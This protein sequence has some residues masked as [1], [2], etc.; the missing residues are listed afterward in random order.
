MYP[1]VDISPL[2]SEQNSLIKE[3]SIVYDLIYTPR[4]T[5]FLQE[6]QKQG[7][8][9]FDGS[10]MLVQQGAIAFEIWT[11]KKP[12]VEVMRQALWNQ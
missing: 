3:G 9:I 11:G 8:I 5:L 10:E 2:T 7:A 4:P 1:N 12:D 6:A